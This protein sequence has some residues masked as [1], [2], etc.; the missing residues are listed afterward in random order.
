M[1]GGSTV[2]RV[3]GF[4]GF[5]AVVHMAYM[6]HRGAPASLYSELK[7]GWT[8]IAHSSEARQVHQELKVLENL[9]HLGTMTALC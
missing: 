6:C 3:P 2:P 7:T 9:A 8:L 5:P 1:W 4:L